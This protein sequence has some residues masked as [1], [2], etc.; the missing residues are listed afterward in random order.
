MRWRASKALLLN[1]VALLASQS[2][3]LHRPEPRG[4]IREVPVAGR[5]A[6]DFKL[7]GYPSHLSVSDLSAMSRKVL[8]RVCQV[9]VSRCCLGGPRTAS[10]EGIQETEARA[11]ELIGKG[12]SGNGGPA[13]VGRT[14]RMTSNE[15]ISE[16]EER[17]G[18]GRSGGGGLVHSNC[19]GRDACMPLWLV[20]QPRKSFPRGGYTHMHTHTRSR[21]HTHARTHARAH[22]HTN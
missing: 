4:V 2:L 8:I 19:A 12:R 3:R 15:G 10:N 11:D 5:A 20:C 14:T 21:T 13:T 22:T 9:T 18:Q 1:L 16:A 6:D 7:R 17:V